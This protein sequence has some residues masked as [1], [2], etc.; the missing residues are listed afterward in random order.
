M[1]GDDIQYVEPTSTFVLFLIFCSLRN[2][3]SYLTKLPREFQTTTISLPMRVLTFFNT[4]FAM[5]PGLAPLA[6]GIYRE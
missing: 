2:V 6:I 3:I 1:Q 5:G 4:N